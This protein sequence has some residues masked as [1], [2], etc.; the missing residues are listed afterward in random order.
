MLSLTRVSEH[1]SLAELGCKDGTPYPIL[2]NGLAAESLGVV[3]EL[4][5]AALGGHP[6]R[7]NSAYRTPEYNKMVGGAANSQHVA[8]NA[9]DLSCPSDEQF[10]EFETKIYQTVLLYNI[11]ADV[12]DLAPVKFVQFYPNKRFVHIDVRS[13]D[14]PLRVRRAPAGQD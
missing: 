1:L 9:I 14:T 4:V 11:I 5:R 10:P 2:V 7:I 12:A 13:T 8:G 6:L 3:F